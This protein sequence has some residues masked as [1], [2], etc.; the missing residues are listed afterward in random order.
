MRL[1]HIKAL[2][3]DSEK[4]KLH[5]GFWSISSDL[6]ELI[7][8]PICVPATIAAAA[9]AAAA[10][11]DIIKYSCITLPASYL[12]SFLSFFMR[13]SGIPGSTGST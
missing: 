1:F 5:L 3:S 6:L 8:F 7:R 11:F 10:G 2:K 13:G 12:L 4:M 9:A